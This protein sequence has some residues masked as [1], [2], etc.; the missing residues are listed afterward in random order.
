MPEMV[1]LG[2]TMV[3]FTPKATGPL[4]YSPQFD[5]TA[6]GAESNVAIGL[7]R[8]G[9]STG[10][11][12][13]LGRDEFGKYVL[14]FIRG[15]GV[16]TSRVRFDPAAPTAVYFKERREEGE[17]RVFYYRKGSAA[18]RLCPDDLDRDYLASARVIHLT[19][20]T[21]ALSESGHAT[22]RQAMQ[23]AREAGVAVSFDPNIRLKLWDA[24]TARQVLL[25]LIPG[26][27]LL[28][29]GKEEAELLLGKATP[30]EHARQFL[31]MGVKQVVLKLGPAGCLVANSEGMQRVDGYPVRRVVDPIGAGDGFAAGYLAGWLNGWDPVRC[32]RVANTCGALATQVT[33]DIEGLP[34][35]DEVEAFITG[36]H[37][38]TR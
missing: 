33:G 8:L 28:Y 1:T 7:A 30:E 36:R 4:R 2:E 23:I 35:M 19:G 34:T 27:D 20:I 24:A 25:D 18:S 11:I 37:Q 12:S 29:P 16:D 10:W 26:V 5:R 21:P 17:S 3:L 31:A 15:E 38:L 22:V 14:S 9:H 6:G 13:R 32:A